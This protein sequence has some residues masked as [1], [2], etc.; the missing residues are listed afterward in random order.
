M[1]IAVSRSPN[2][3]ELQP[4]VRSI[5]AYA[6][7]DADVELELVMPRTEGQLLVN[8]FEP[9]LRHWASRDR[10]A[11]RIGPVGLQGAQ[12]RPLLIDTA[13]KRAVCGV[14][15][16]TGGLTAFHE[17]PATDFTDA[18]VDAREV[19]GDAAERLHADLR[20]I[21]DGGAQVDRLEAFLV[22]RV[23]ERAEEDA[24]LRLR[25]DALRAGE[26]VTEARE[27]AGLSQRAMHALFDRR[28]GLRPKLFAR[29]ERFV[30]ALDAASDRDS[31]A[32]LALEVG[33][34]DQAHFSREFAALAGQPPSRHAQ[35]DAEPRHARFGSGETFKKPGGR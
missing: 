25:S 23:R 3:S 15:F 32:D 1:P 17:W 6:S 8:L 34:S 29:I 14:A 12:T 5:W 13:Q 16:A 18:I 24:R 2:A 31:W 22:E 33:F 21:E 10:I 27:Q 4:W 26:G 19:W 9:E 28:I 30:A 7:P 20:A 11:R 35:I